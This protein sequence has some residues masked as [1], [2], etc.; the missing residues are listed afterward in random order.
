MQQR[1]RNSFAMKDRCEGLATAGIG[2]EVATITLWV[3]RKWLQIW[4]FIPV[5]AAGLV[6]FKPV[7][8][9]L[10]FCKLVSV[11]GLCLLLASAT[12]GWVEGL[13][14]HVGNLHVIARKMLLLLAFP[15]AIRGSELC[16]ISLLA[17]RIS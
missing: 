5:C 17:V 15:Y 8:A 16:V 2:A 3:S 9:G 11:A 7:P 1:S 4:W 14:V 10:Q 12:D 13:G 6:L